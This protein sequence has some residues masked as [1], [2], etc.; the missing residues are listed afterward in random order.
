M[1]SDI[2]NSQIRNSN[3]AFIPQNIQ[4]QTQVVES[5]QSYIPV[6]NQSTGN[7]NSANSPHYVNISVQNSATHNRENSKSDNQN[8]VVHHPGKVKNTTV[9]E[10]SQRQ[11]IEKPEKAEKPY[12]NIAICSSGGSSSNK[13][14]SNKKRTT[15]G[16]NKIQ[17]AENAYENFI[18]DRSNVIFNKP[19]MY[20][21]T[22]EGYKLRKPERNKDDEN[23]T[24]LYE[25]ISAYDNRHRT[26][27][28]LSE[29]Q[30]HNSSKTQKDN[31]ISM[32]S[33]RDRKLRVGERSESNLRSLLKLSEIRELP[34][35][36]TLPKNLHELIVREIP[37]NKKDSDIPHRSQQSS[38]ETATTLNPSKSHGSLI[39]YVK[40]DKRNDT[41][42]IQGV[43]LNFLTSKEPKSRSS[44]E[45]ELRFV[46]YQCLSS[47]QDD[48][49]YR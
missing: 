29:Y 17:K 9:Y 47:S 37:N 41:I 39:D 1:E 11:Y 20:N 49:D 45:D 4:R 33:T 22:D 23:P 26:I 18:I 13:H 15:S 10:K 7:G 24:E 8:V 21:A 31:R 27:I 19:E 42:T 46:S 32:H 43:P 34:I 44:N 28:N 14:I 36:R 38:Y 5:M 12:E 16:Y 48:D 25:E 30:S 6:S 2:I 40:S 3:T 35:H